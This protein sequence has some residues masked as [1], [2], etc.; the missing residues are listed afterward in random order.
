MIPIRRHLNLLPPFP[1]SSLPLSRLPRRR[2]RRSGPAL[3]GLGSARLVLEREVRVE[4]VDAPREGVVRP[5]DEGVGA[6][7]VAAQGRGQGRGAGLELTQLRAE[8][9]VG[10]VH[11]DVEEGDGG[12]GVLGDLVCEPEGADVFLLAF[13]VEGGVVFE[14]EDEAVDGLPGWVCEWALMAMGVEEG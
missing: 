9:E 4:V 8:L 2:R 1:L 5:A 3:L 13:L 6:E 12:A 10:H 14:E 11:D 7:L